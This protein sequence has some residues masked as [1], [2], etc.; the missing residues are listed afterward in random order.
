MLKKADK[1][2]KRLQRHKRVRRK[3][4]G[5]P[6]RPRLCVFRSS[7]NIYAQIIDDTNRV[8]LVAA[9]SLDEAVKG[10]VNHT[11][12]KEAAKMV[13]EMVAKKAVEKGIT[14]VVFDRGGYIYH[15]RIKELAEGAREAGLKF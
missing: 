3:V 15:G 13:G 12:N 5:T 7:N 4:F 9:S 6:Q 14:E 2:A 1:N 11:G 8:T 10:A